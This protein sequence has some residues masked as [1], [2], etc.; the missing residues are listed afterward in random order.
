MITEEINQQIT[1]P[2]VQPGVKKGVGLVRSAQLVTVSDIISLT[3][4]VSAALLAYR[5][6]LRP[7]HRGIQPKSTQAGFYSIPFWHTHS[8]MR[9]GKNLRTWPPDSQK[10]SLFQKHWCWEY[11]EMKQLS[12]AR[13]APASSKY[14]SNVIR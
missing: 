1:T 12:E 2:L 14:Y 4:L 5:C 9:R 8:Y 11:L 6:Y 13:S 10:Y 7:L 3:S